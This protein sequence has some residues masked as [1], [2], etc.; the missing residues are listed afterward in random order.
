M[1]RGSEPRRVVHI[2]KPLVSWKEIASYLGVTPRTAQEW[3]KEGG[4]PVHREG[5]PQKPTVIAHPAELDRWRE[6][7]RLAGT[8]SD[9]APTEVPKNKRSIRTRLILS[10]VMLILATTVFWATRPDA[11]L[12]ALCR[13][14]GNMLKAFDQRGGLLWAAETPDLDPALSQGGHHFDLYQI[15]D[16]DGDGRPEVLFNL[17]FQTASTSYGKLICFDSA[18]R[19]RWE[20]S[21]GRAKK[22]EDRVFN[23]HYAGRLVRPVSAGGRNYV[24]VSATHNT[25]FPCQ[26]SLLDASTG[27]LVSE[28]WHPGWLTSF[29]T[30]DLDGDGN[31]E[32]LL[33]G[34][35]NPGVNCL[36]NAALVALKIPFSPPPGK[37][38]EEERTWKFGGGEFRYC[39]FPSADLFLIRNQK[40]FV[41]RLWVGV[42]GNVEALVSNTIDAGLH[43]SLDNAFGPL[44]LVPQDSFLIMHKKLRQE[45]LVDHDVTEEELASLNRT[46]LYET[47]PSCHPHP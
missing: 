47:A 27:E 18:G 44:D 14:E 38:P 1:R 29:Q 23:E 9:S 7:R 45:G 17:R 4:L 35:N 20:Y 31:P 24:L 2:S 26:V 8:G 15:V 33:G 3:E 36:G 12:P 22:W 13:V 16:L 42:R 10:V 34:T 11:R 25:W 40:L 41:E 30:H 28:Y 21:Y 19:I 32:I 39:I 37:T 5:N 46:Y 6:Q 43:Y